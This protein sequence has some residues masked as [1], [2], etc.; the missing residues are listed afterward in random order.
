MT[1][2][3]EA[4]RWRGEAWRGVATCD[5]TWRGEAAAAAADR[6]AIIGRAGPLGGERVPL[7]LGIEGCLAAGW[8]G[9]EPTQILP[10]LP[11]L[12]PLN[13]VLPY[14]GLPL[15]SEI[16]HTFLRCHAPASH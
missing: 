16:I 5:E 8:R 6:R 14:A 11:Q 15:A 3:G 2:F 13:E 12:V 1:R 4:R 7:P 10:P 9:K